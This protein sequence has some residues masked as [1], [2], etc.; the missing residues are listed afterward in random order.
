[1]D[2]A[3]I[4]VVLPGIENHSLGALKRAARRAGLEAMIVRFGGWP[5]ID[6]V[7][8]EVRRLSPRLCGISIQTT[9]AAL[10]SLSLAK[11]LRSRGYA[12]R[13]IC[14]GHFA[15]LNAEEILRAPSGV[16][17][18]VRFAGEE[19]LVG[20]AR[21]G[22]EDELA[23]LP[24]VL[25]RR[26]EGGV[27]VGAPARLRD[28][29]DEPEELGLH[30][31]FPSADVIL[32]RGCEAR[33]A[34]CCVAG[35]AD[36]A[37]TEAERG[38]GGAE[39]ARHVRGSID[40]IAD[41]IAS[42]WR[43]GARVFSFMD[44]NLLP[45]DPGEAE[46]WLRTLHRA[47]DRRS[48]GKFAFS[49]QLRAD[50]V[51][52]GVADALGDLG[53]ARAY[54][55]VDAASTSQLRALGR[56][57]RAE[58]GPVALERLAARGAFVVCNALFLGPTFRFEPLQEEI[59]ALAQIRH[60]PLHLLPI[61][62]RVGTTY[63]DAAA[64]RG[65]IEGG[66]L[67]KHYR[68]VDERT[69]ILA[70]ILTSFPSRLAERSV[71][72]GLY[73]LGESLGVARRL[74]PTVDIAHQAAVY[75][76][77]ALQWNADQIRLLRA[78]AGIAAT[79]DR[80]AARALIASEAISVRAHDEALL[81]DCDRALAAL[82]RAVSLASGRAVRAPR[83]GRLI[84]SV[85][86]AMGLAGCQRD[87][88]S[89]PADASMDAAIADRSV[90]ID[91]SALYDL[92][93][94]VGDIANSDLANV[95]CASGTFHVPDGSEQCIPCQLPSGSVEITVDANGAV[96]GVAA[97]NGG[98]LPADVATCL[99]DYFKGYCYPSLAG[100][101]AKIQSHCWIA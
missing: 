19:A 55:G 101:T 97:D 39:A 62:A 47:L 42:L 6:R 4:G 10:A 12:G 83:R 82:E 21:G 63:H 73:D 94:P 84:S 3:L 20:L 40:R 56:H 29:I 52:E 71:P 5:D 77:V 76:R 27:R 22:D 37:E 45:L 28:E 18:V 67:W 1:M 35:V 86:V 100:R 2:I 66:F 9:E 95:M 80:D 54:V 34:Y 87:G 85:M 78:S 59:E 17:A 26:S 57:S 91:A 38:G 99:K 51:S 89:G 74:C 49:M 32:S 68:F 65:L 15:T 61:D 58:A 14:G 79:G 70:E 23:A 92:I 44:D 69:E 75:A 30:L 33:C 25:L 16:D 96:V 60:A 7:I 31:G 50:T 24:G 81:A 90:L 93:A 53:L 98:M 88:L 46:T 72:I 11:L 13:I 43:R 48:V 64:R 41:R 8:A 36:L